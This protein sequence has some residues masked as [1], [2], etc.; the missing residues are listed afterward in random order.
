ME[1]KRFKEIDIL[2]GMAIVLVLLGHAIIVYPVNLHKILWC[3]VL[4][5]WLSTVHM[6]LFFL[7]SGF[8]Y[9][10]RTNEYGRF[11]WK[12]TKRLLIP[13]LAFC[14]LD[15]LVRIAFGSLVNQ[16]RGLLE[17]VKN[18]ILAGGGDWF[19]YV[20][21]IIFLIFPFI[22]KMIKKQPKVIPLLLGVLVLLEA[23]SVLPDIMML[24]S[25]GRYL[26]YFILGY[27][28]KR[29]IARIKEI[30]MRIKSKDILL[31]LGVVVL[32]AMCVR[33][34][35]IYGMNPILKLVAALL[36]II[37]MWF[38]AD[39]ISKKKNYLLNQFSKYSLPLYL[40]NGYLLVISRTIVVSK[41]NI[42][43]PIIIIAFNMF[44]TLFLAWIFIKYVIDKVKIFRIIFGME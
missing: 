42:T 38:V 8:C 23:F 26:I 5:T 9:S 24:E 3:N 10:F 6:P 22:E 37:A 20:L 30:H 28:G 31:F 13:Y 25:V 44:V 17:S 12:K 11:W 43:N 33:W 34:L 27:L 19:L 29:W 2:R 41:W 35:V 40:M 15:M 7:I 4:F 1:K 16:Q 36:G 14:I 39:S 21:Y 18:M 32:W